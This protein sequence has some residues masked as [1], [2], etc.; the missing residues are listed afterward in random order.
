MD[1]HIRRILYLMMTN[2]KNKSRMHNFKT[3]R[4]KSNLNN[5]KNGRRNKET[6]KGIQG[7]ILNK[8]EKN[9]IIMII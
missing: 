9:D 4:R 2:I 6:K 3:N 7:K 1:I 8:I 5:E